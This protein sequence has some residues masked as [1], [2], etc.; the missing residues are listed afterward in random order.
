MTDLAKI[1]D[2]LAELAREDTIAAQERGRAA[3]LIVESKSEIDQR[4]GRPNDYGSALNMMTGMMTAYL[5]PA[6]IGE[7]AELIRAAIRTIDQRAGRPRG[8]SSRPP[9][10]DPTRIAELRALPTDRWDFRRLIELC[11]ELNVAA[12]NDCHMS[13]GYIIRTI[14]NHVP[15]VFGLGDFKQLVSNY[16]FPKSV[17]AAMQR[18][19][20]QG[21]DGADFHLHQPIRTHETLPTATQVAFSA[22][23]DVLLGEVIRVTRTPKSGG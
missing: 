20:G 19:Q 22:E 9:F 21:R 18:L 11:R 3:A 6:K 12:A 5:D 7:A 4:L 17:K 2:E 1:A 15:P 8:L 10:V 14:L 16:S 23:L 13:T